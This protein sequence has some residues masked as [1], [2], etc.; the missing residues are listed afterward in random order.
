MKLRRWFLMATVGLIAVG[1]TSCGSPTT[2]AKA[3]H[4]VGTKTSTSPVPTTIATTSTVPALGS[5]VKVAHLGGTLNLTATQ[6]VRTGDPV[7]KTVMLSVTLDHVLDPAPLSPSAAGPTPGDHLVELTYSVTNAESMPFA[8]PPE[9]PQEPYYPSLVFTVDNA[10]Y[11]SEPQAPPTPSFGYGALSTSQDQF[12][13]IAPGATAMERIGFPLPIGVPVVNAAVSLRLDS[14]SNGSL[15]EWLIPSTT[16]PVSA[17]TSTTVSVGSVPPTNTEVAHLGGPL[18][19]TASQPLPAQVETSV[20]KITLDQV[21]DPAPVSAFGMPMPNDRWVAL[22][23]TLSNMALV[24]VPNTGG[25]RGQLYVD[26][27]VN[28]IR[29]F[30][31]L[32]TCD[33]HPVQFGLSARETVTRC[34]AVQLPIGVP[35][36]IASATLLYASSGSNQTT[37]EWLVP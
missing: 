24:Y 2:A 33:N 34:L 8:N 25:V 20:V 29:E 22:R 12:A 35:V 37:G 19:L 6:S 28:E 5:K 16:A 27:A 36:V 17:T 10:N 11:T 21:I 1:T 23:F 18:T 14:S 9:S 31:P 26:W 30:V 15:G 3:R 13:T 4:S 7:N 32:S